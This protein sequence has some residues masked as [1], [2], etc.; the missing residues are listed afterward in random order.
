M[1]MDKKR[2]A[3][4]NLIEQLKEQEHREKIERYKR[5]NGMVRKGQILFCGSSL[6]E[7]FPVHELLV[8]AGVPLAVYNRGVSGY[9]TMELAQMLD[10]LVFDLQPGYVFIN[11]G[12]NDM[13]EK[14][15]RVEDMMGRYDAILTEIRQGLPEAKLFVMAYYPCN[16]KVLMAD[17]MRGMHFRYRTNERIAEANEALQRLAEKHG[18]EYLDL[19]SGL[20]DEDGELKAEYTVD[21]IHMYG[22][23]YMKVLELLLPV[24]ENLK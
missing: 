16:R 1:S 20:V 23:G 6:M 4:A 12:T 18:A 21:G 15:F 2:A 5:L 8:D 17:L 24:L 10:T 14:E 9:T 3:A 19:N 11:I 13:N 22:N 7:E